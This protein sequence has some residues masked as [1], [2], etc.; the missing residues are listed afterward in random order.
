MKKFLAL[1]LVACL[2]LAACST[3]WIAQAQAIVQVMLPAAINI[4]SLVSAFSGAKVDPQVVAEMTQVTS[5]VNADLNQLSALLADY[6]NLPPAQKATRIQQINDVLNIL[7]Q[8]TN[9]L[10]AAAHI[11]DA[12]LQAK[13]TA[14]INLVI[15][16]V[17]SIES[18]IPIL[19]GNKSAKSARAMNYVSA[20][21]FRQRYNATMTAPT[22]APDI[23]LK[24]KALAIR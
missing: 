22:A 18:L 16:E 5:E 2:T 10:L 21:Q 7:Q 19:Q 17:Q 23:D 20:Q 15:S 4:L 1:V 8:H 9:D 14:V 11:K 6:N 12:V 24:A 3:S 13:V